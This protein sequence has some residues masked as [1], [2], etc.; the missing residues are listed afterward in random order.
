M[1]SLELL[2]SLTNSCEQI[3]SIVQKDLLTLSKDQLRWKSNENSWSII[4][5]LEHIVLSGDYYLKE[6]KKKFDKKI[7]SNTP[8]N[9]QY[10][11]G[12]IGNYST[13][14][15]EPKEGKI[16]VKMKTLKRMKPGKSQLDTDRIIDKFQNYQKETLALLDKSRFYDLGKIKINS[17]LG[18]LIRFKLGDAFRFVIAHNQRHMLQAKNVMKYPG[19]PES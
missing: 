2:K 7:P 6:I 19:F 9:I 5:C 4:E 14:S 8:I 17:S 18:I 15:M 12:L 1:K 3:N 11:P 13:K 10:N 16:K